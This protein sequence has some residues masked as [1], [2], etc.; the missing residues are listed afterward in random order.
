MVC[1]EVFGHLRFSL[2]DAAPMFEA[3]MRA[4]AG[5][6]GISEEYVPPEQ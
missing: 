1:L 2:T 3:E 5:Q 6:L 4:I